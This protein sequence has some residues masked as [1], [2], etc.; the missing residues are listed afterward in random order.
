MRLCQRVGLS[1]SFYWSLFSLLKTI[2]CSGD[3]AFVGKCIYREGLLGVWGERRKQKGN[4]LK[5]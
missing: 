4:F 2:W 5:C 3:Q 1:P